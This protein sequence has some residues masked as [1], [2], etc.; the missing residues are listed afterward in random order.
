MCSKTAKYNP[1]GHIRIVPSLW[2]EDLRSRLV[3]LKND[4]YISL[5]NEGVDFS[6]LNSGYAYQAPDR[7]AIFLTWN[8]RYIANTSLSQKKNAELAKTI[9]SRFDLDR[10]VVL[11]VI[12]KTYPSAPNYEANDISDREEE[13]IV[14]WFKSKFVVVEYWRSS[15]PGMS[16]VIQKP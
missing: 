11:Q 6:R 1:N 15:S 3:K 7:I 2:P 9:A 8:P 5:P 14:D 13:D 4:G 16:F 10:D 12:E